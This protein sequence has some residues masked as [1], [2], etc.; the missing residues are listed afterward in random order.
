MASVNQ[1]AKAENLEV[2]AVCDPWNK[3]RE[4]AA[5]KAKEWFGTEA[6][7]C[8]NYYDLL[9]LPEIDAVMIAS[10]DHWHATH[11]EAAAKAGRYVYIE[12]PMAIEIDE[13]N[14]A[15]EVAKKSGVVIQ[16]GT[17]VRS[18]ASTAGCRAVVRAGILGK[19]S[20][21]EQVR[22]GEKPYW[23]NYLNPDVQATDLDWQEFTKDRTKKSFNPILYSGWYGYWEFSQGPVPQWAVHFLDTI[24]FITGLG[25]PETC[26][27][28]GGVYTWK[29]EHNFTA[30]DQVQALWQYPEGVLVS[31]ATNFGNSSGNCLRICGDKGTLE[32]GTLDSVPT[33]SARGGNNRN[34]SIRGEHKVAPVE[35]TDHWVNWYRCM[36]SG[37][38]PNAPLDAGYQHSIASIMATLSYETGRR[39]RFDAKKRT[40]TT[41]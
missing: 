13:L 17:Q 14:R 6:K 34:G 32:M 10:C 22:N 38:T 5:A 11:L 41:V 2:V 25:L 20:R 8:R 9:E 36:R 1:H 23:Y 40:I 31:Y 7:Q 30:P 21:I 15:Y 26:F 39:S 19:L 12:K 33:Y 29:D 4:N 37:D 35:Q 27:S 18:L 24:H 28:M 16:V 3:A